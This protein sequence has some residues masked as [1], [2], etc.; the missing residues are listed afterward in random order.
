MLHIR[1]MLHLVRSMKWATAVDLSMGYYHM[2]LNKE[3]CNACIIILPWGK[4]FYNALTMGFCG[5]TDIFQHAMGN[6]FADLAH[7]LVY[8]DDIIIIGSGSYEDLYAGG[9]SFSES[10]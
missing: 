1:D 5:S 7:V 8:L 6:L 9:R 3:S 10:V 2:K 4:Y